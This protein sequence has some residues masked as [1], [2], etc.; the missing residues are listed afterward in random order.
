MKREPVVLKYHIEA[1]DN[2][3]TGGTIMSD[4]AIVA[5][6][7]SG[8][9]K[10]LRDRFKIDGYVPGRITFPDGSSHFTTLD[11]EEIS[12]EDYYG[13]MKYKKLMYKTGTTAPE[14]IEEVYEP[15]LKEGRD[16]LT[17]TLSSGMSATC[18]M[19]QKAAKDMMGK[20]PER[21]IV[22]VDSLRFST[23]I[24][25]MNM[26]ASEMRDAG[27]S[28]DEVAAWLEENK[29]RFHQIG[30]M[31]DLH[32]LARAGRVSNFKA[33]FG[34][35]VG[36]NALGDFNPQGVSQVLCNVKGKM[37]ALKAT[38]EYVKQTAVDPENQVMFIGHTFKD[39]VVDIL[40]EM[41]EEAVH[42]KEIIITRV[43]MS[44][45]ANIGPGM[46]GVYYIGNEAT[47]GLKE[48]TAIMEKIAAEL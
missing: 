11:W 2:K 47:E 7:A 1:V 9:H 10:E 44:C 21:K 29:N 26:K 22:I 34:T 38:V 17:I 23:L 40:K 20:Y 48:E 27:C 42:P 45:G 36:V 37:K 46:I 15:F 6:C 41:V 14:N 8:L 16:I 4:F 3:E 13:S 30:P 12:P 32:F 28:I 25:M 35:M 33:F 43:D 31:D 39:D 18:S 24:A 5:E 19:F